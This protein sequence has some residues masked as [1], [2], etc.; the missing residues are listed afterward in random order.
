MWMLRIW[1][2]CYLDNSV[3]TSGY[4]PLVSGLD[5]DRAHPAAVTTDDLNSNQV[6]FSP[7]YQ[8]M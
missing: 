6:N 1:M 7:T 3:S 8:L 2:F 5:I 4:K